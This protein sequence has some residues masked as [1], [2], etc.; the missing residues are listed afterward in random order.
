[1][2]L[3]FRLLTW[4]DVYLESRLG[5]RFKLDG[6]HLFWLATYLGGVVFLAPP[7][8][9]EENLLAIVLASSIAGPEFATGAAL[10]S[11]AAFLAY[12]SPMA[13]G[14]VASVSW[15]ALTAISWR[16]SRRLRSAADIPTD[17]Q[18]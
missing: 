13:F 11:G 1:M 2:K 18:E 5:R 12:K 14:I 10:W 8:L 9:L 3:P 6:W 17:D 16:R 15:A 7:V 4:K